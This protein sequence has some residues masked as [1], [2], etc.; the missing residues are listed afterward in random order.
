MLRCTVEPGFK[1][2]KRQCLS[3]Y[4]VCYGSEL[5]GN[6]EQLLIEMVSGNE[7]LISLRY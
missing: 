6:M 7:S 4:E 5:V 3:D 1:V 2:L